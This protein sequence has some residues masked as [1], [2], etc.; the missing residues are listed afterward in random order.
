M[1]LTE[2]ELGAML[3]TLARA[4]GLALV[5]PV[6]ADAPVRA[7]LVFVVAI[8]IGVG[9]NRGGIPLAEV[10][11]HVAIELAAGLVTGTV[12]RFVVARAAIAGQ[13]VGL[14]LGLGFASQFDPDAGESASTLRAVFTTLAGLAFLAVGGLEAIVRACG[15]PE[16]SLIEIGHQGFA[17]L[18]QAAAAFG[19]GLSI[20]GPV[21]LAALVGNLGFAVMNRAAPAVNVFSIS[22]GAVLILGGAI[23]IGNAPQLIGSLHGVGRDAAHASTPSTPP[24]ASGH[25]SAKR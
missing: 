18:D 24:T 7:R 4:S 17:L 20:A 13:L 1:S 3:A 10:P 19:H 23:L 8:A 21:V 11:T 25:S 22:L 14:S 15:G 9:L 6:L 5:A 12:V 2:S 16:P